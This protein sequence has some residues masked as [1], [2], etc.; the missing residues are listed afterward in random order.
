MRMA[1]QEPPSAWVERFA[2]LI[3]SHGTVLDLACGGGRHTRYLLALGYRVVA[4]DIDVSGVT[5]LMGARDLE[6]IQADLESKAWPFAERLFDGIVVTNYL[7]RPHLSSLPDSLA[8][9]GVLIFETFAKG[10]E[11]YGRPRNP[12]FLLKPNELLEA[13][14]SK[15]TILAY[16]HGFEPDPRPAMRQRICAIRA[17]D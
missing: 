15:L 12:D 2:P 17:R 3:N 7:H 1:K 4:V 10:N 14:S 16:E 6:I 13:F 5:D 11:R 9:G 8:P